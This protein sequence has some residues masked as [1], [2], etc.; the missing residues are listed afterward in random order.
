MLAELQHRVDLW[1]AA[2]DAELTAAELMA[3]A[4]AVVATKVALVPAVAAAEQVG[5]L[6]LPMEHVTPEGQQ[7]RRQVGD[8]G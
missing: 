2:D 3:R 5:R 7:P 8:C 6:T 1:A 4:L